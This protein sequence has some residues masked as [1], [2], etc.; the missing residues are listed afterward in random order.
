MD[1]T[2]GNL[3]ELDGVQIVLQMINPMYTVFAKMVSA[4]QARLK[5]GHSRDAP[6]NTDLRNFLFH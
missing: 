6:T 1:A 5:F 2:K 3:K 4:C